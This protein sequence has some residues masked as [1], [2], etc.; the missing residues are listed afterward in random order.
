MQ[1]TRTIV[2]WVLLVAMLLS[3]PGRAMGH[4]V[5]TL[6]MAEA[7]AACPLCHGHATAAQSGPVVGNTCCKY[8]SGR[9]AAI[10]ALTPAK[11]EGAALAQATLLPADA[12]IGFLVSPDRQPDACALQRT[13]LR[14]PTSGY[15]SNFLRL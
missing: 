8:V 10:P 7:G 3:L 14:T 12:R 5:C 2:P 6:G 4:F 1:A 13:A 11:I 9:S 15:R